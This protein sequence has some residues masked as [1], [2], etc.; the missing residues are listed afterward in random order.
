MATT[1]PDNRPESQPAGHG[2]VTREAMVEYLSLQRWSR[3]S[4]AALPLSLGLWLSLLALV[5][6][7]AHTET[8]FS[9]RSAMTSHLMDLTA[10][11]SKGIAP[12]QLPKE[13][14]EQDAASRCRCACAPTGH[15]LCRPELP[16]VAGFNGSIMMDRF[17]HLRAR[18]AYHKDSSPAASRSMRWEELRGIP[19]VWFWVQHGLIPAIWH[20]EPQ[21]APL[22][23]ASMFGTEATLGDPHTQPGRLLRW[24]Q[25]VGG[26]RM[27]QRRIEAQDCIGDPRLIERYEQDCHGIEPS[28]EAFGPGALEEGYY[29]EGFM[30]EAAERGAFDVY[31]DIQSPVHEVLE[32]I[33]YMLKAH[34]W[35]DDSTDELLLQAVF[36]NAEAMPALYG[37]LEVRFLF[38][39]SGSLRH[40]IQVRTTAADEYPNEIYIALDVT[41]IS[42]VFLLLLQCVWEVIWHLCCFDASS[43]EQRPLLNFWTALDWATVVVSLAIFCGRVLIAWSASLVAEAMIGIPS[44]APAYGADIPETK[45]YHSAWGSA[46]DKVIS[47]TRWME[48]YRLALFAYSIVLT[49]QIFKVL[50]GQP[51][52]AQLA[53]ALLHA[54][55]DLIHFVVVFLVLF[56]SFAFS[57]FMIFGLV[58][59]EWSTPTGAMNSCFRSVLGFT[60]LEAMYEVAP[61]STVMWYWL[62]LSVMIFLMMNLLLAVTYDHYILVK[63]TCGQGTG[64]FAQLQAMLR[65]MMNRSDWGRLCSFCSRDESI[66][67]HS[68]LLEEL[69]VR[70]DFSQE[71][72]RGIHFSVLGAK[73]Y[74]RER[75]RQGFVQGEAGTDPSQLAPPLKP[76]MQDFKHLGI[77]DEYIE[78]LIEECKAHS[79][80]EYGAEE[81]RVNQ[82]RE[83]VNQ[84]EEDIAAMRDR[85]ADCQE[86]TKAAMYHMTSRLEFLERMVHST[87]AELVVI[88][89]AAG[90]PDAK[91]ATSP[92]Q[93]AKL[94][95]TVGALR[96]LSPA[97][98]SE[99]LLT[100]SVSR[101]L[102]HL[103]RGDEESR[104]ARAGVEEWTRAMRRIDTR[105]KRV[106]PEAR[107]G[108]N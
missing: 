24:S 25:I 65:D 26:V 16:T 2:E 20:E 5:S 56:L 54:V 41:W 88:A 7:R 14:A 86:K 46:L 69:M 83:L 93:R 28:V 71:E 94:D 36:L 37:L 104:A 45:A 74:R 38:E 19:D 1:M 48:Y 27:R 76:V 34:D 107:R 44:S 67:R 15:D 102:E 99:S 23:T 64:V 70:C 29:A 106:L 57:G 39:R 8:S 100:G 51:K 58:L 85:L 33:E 108:S 13:V 35:L 105:G 62:F 17:K 12:E 4:C 52:L 55:E 43:A 81:T 79:C 40:S 42:L 53:S 91:P 101:V 66:P 82:L 87:L 77:D 60:D 9:I 75:K 6:Y 10:D 3:Q 50:R 68:E 84:A 59:E 31:L 89:G 103:G 11:L 30:P 95:S 80:R 90:V 96:S 18:A 49:L 78:S 32:M 21:N 63:I 98:R 97:A 47:L 92:S 73:W 61:V 72:R 22:D